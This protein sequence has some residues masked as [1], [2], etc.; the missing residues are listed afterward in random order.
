MAPATGVK[1]IDRPIVL[2][3]VEA[4]E[5]AA[6]TFRA[7]PPLF[8]RGPPQSS[9]WMAALTHHLK[10]L[11]ALPERV[12]LVTLLR[13]R[14]PASVKRAVSKSSTFPAGLSESFCALGSWKRRRF[15]TASG[16]PRPNTILT[17]PCPCLAPQVSRET[18]RAANAAMTGRNQTVSGGGVREPD[19]D[20]LFP[21]HRA[22]LL[23]G[24]GFRPSFQGGTAWH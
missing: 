21:R 20:H 7:A 1:R 23:S 5:A 14:S 12:L 3:R 16:M 4:R 17:A 22:W 24:D 13:R 10:H 6:A 9:A 8:A 11:Y 18:V 15:P 2:G 19:S